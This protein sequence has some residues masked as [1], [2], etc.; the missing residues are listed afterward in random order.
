MEGAHQLPMSDVERGDHIVDEARE[1][2]NHAKLKGI[3]IK[4]SPAFSDPI[5][6]NRRFWYNGDN[7]GIE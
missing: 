7:V 6:F 3:V 1:R 4:T 2:K 5:S